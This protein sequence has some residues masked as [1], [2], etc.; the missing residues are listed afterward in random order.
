VSF[1]IFV[2]ASAVI[3]YVL[4]GYPLVAAT[5]ARFFPQRV[6][7]RFLPRTVT[8]LLPVHNGD[9]WL[10]AKLRTIREL[11]YPPELVDVI[12]ISS[13]SQDRTASI[14]R[15]H[16]GPRLRVIELERPGKAVAL[17][18][19]LAAATGEI[20]F[21]TDVRQALDPYCLRELVANFAD[22]RVG[23]VSGELLI[24]DGQTREEV[25]VGLYWKYEKLIRSCQSRIDSIPGATGSIRNGSAFRTSNKDPR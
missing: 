21:L 20:L 18:A 10:E 14:S 3:M 23:V 15:E 9:R 16:A 25:S 7:K 11:D 13:A 4:I 1:S 17:N 5:W 8:I 19:G 6:A 24:R 22:P 2:G 12:V